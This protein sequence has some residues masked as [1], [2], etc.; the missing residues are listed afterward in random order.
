M[1][2][3]HRTYR[4]LLSI[5]LCLALALCLVPLMTLPGSALSDL[6]ITATM[7]NIS[8]TSPHERRHHVSAT[9][10]MGRPGILCEHGPDAAA[11]PPGGDPVL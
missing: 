3:T 1:K 8:I 2:N 5:L 10:E 9:G 6:P 4:P 11:L 7:A